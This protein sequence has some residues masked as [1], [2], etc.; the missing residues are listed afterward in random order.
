MPAANET[1]LRRFVDEVVN[2]GEFGSLEELVHDDYVYRSPGE[3]IRGRDGLA[4]LFGAYR[5]AFPDLRME[6]DELVAAGDTTVMT[7]TL[8]GTH[9]GN[10]LGHAPTDRRFKIHGMI[11]SHFREGRITDEWEILDQLGLFEQLGLVGRTA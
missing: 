7:F 4:A 2:R 10:L 3:E 11:R 1:V 6:I 5:G 9:R 8:T